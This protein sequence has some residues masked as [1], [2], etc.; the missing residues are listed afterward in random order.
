[1]DSEPSTHLSAGVSRGSVISQTSSTGSFVLESVD[2]SPEV[3]QLQHSSPPAGSGVKVCRQLAQQRE[4][5]PFSPYSLSRGTSAKGNADP[6]QSSSRTGSQRPSRNSSRGSLLPAG[7]LGSGVRQHSTDFTLSPYVLW[8]RKSTSPLRGSKGVCQDSDNHEHLHH[9]GELNGSGGSATHG[10]TTSGIASPNTPHPPPSSRPHRSSFGPPPQLQSGPTILTQSGDTAVGVGSRSCSPTA[11][12]EGEH[13]L[14][15]TVT[16]SSTA[17]PTG[18]NTVPPSP[19]KWNLVE[20]PQENTLLSANPSGGVAERSSSQMD[21][22]DT[23]PFIFSGATSASDI[24]PEMGPP[25]VPTPPSSCPDT[26]SRGPSMLQVDSSQVSPA[27]SRKEGST[28]T[29]SR[30]GGGLGGHAGSVADFDNMGW[31][32]SRQVSYAYRTMS[33]YEDNRTFVLRSGAKIEDDGVGNSMIDDYLMNEEPFQKTQHSKV[34][35][36]YDTKTEMDTPASNKRAIKKIRLP[37]VEESGSNSVSRTNSQQSASGGVGA[38]EISDKDLQ[39][40]GHEISIWKGLSNRYIVPLYK[41]LV[42]SDKRDA[43]LVMEF[44]EG[45]TLLNPSKGTPSDDE[46]G[47]SDEEGDKKVVPQS[48]KTRRQLPPTFTS[49]EKKELSK[50]GPKQYEPLPMDDIQRYIEQLSGALTYLHGKGI[51]HYDVK[52]ENVLLTD[53]SGPSGRNEVRLTDFGTSELQSDRPSATEPVMSF[54]GSLD[55]FSETSSFDAGA[56]ARMASMGFRKNFIKG[57]HKFLAPEAFRPIPEGAPQPDTRPLDMWA[58]G[59]TLYAM[60]TGHFPFKGTNVNAIRDSATHDTPYYPPSMEKAVKYLCERL[61]RK[62]PSTRWTAAKLYA[63]LH[64]RRM[65]G[66]LASKRSRH[67]SISIPSMTASSQTTT[68]ASTPSRS[69]THTQAISTDPLPPPMTTARESRPDSVVTTTGVLS[70]TSSTEAIPVSL[71]SPEGRKHHQ[72][73]AA[74]AAA[75]AD[76]NNLSSA[77]ISRQASGNHLIKLMRTLSHQSNATDNT[78]LDAREVE[79][80]ASMPYA[81]H[82]SHPGEHARIPGIE[83]SQVDRVSSMRTDRDE[84]F[85]SGIPSRSQSP[86]ESFINIPPQ[87]VAGLGPLQNNS[88]GDD[89]NLDDDAGAMHNSSNSGNSSSDNYLN[90]DMMFDG[91]TSFALSKEQQSWVM[92]QVLREARQ[93]G[94]AFPAEED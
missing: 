42:S 69:P 31:E 36:A 93:A 50:C 47:S 5:M 33:T 65:D 40:L 25:S 35:L 12:P 46:S 78:N 89:A 18:E 52:P 94:S 15:S 29:K 8:G 84:V 9:H 11:P 56:A 83:Y 81:T 64:K 38:K 66:A 63:T 53:N 41:V 34:Y 43:Y 10:L 16:P 48:P 91:G 67:A 92:E 22:R 88:V 72:L 75:A 71:G 57:T 58:L 90:G 19:A 20:S 27:N 13:Y 4:L 62:D 68:T 6:P 37:L 3:P 59:V 45:G 17:T 61:L 77:P 1:M 87:A 26:R 49:A 2:H 30:L 39:R 86:A 85:T 24:P 51:T 55:T 28:I 80:M 76:P 44:M 21:P 73:L 79:S 60:A 54:S 74:R 14:D 70:S 23:S 82:R 32:V 7:K